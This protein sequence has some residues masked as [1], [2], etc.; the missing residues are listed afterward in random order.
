MIGFDE[1]FALVAQVARP[2][3]PETVGVSAARG[4]ILAAPITAMMDAPPADVSAMDGYAARQRDLE[5]GGTLHLVGTSYP[6]AGFAGGV[7][8][9]ECVRIFTGAPL[10]EGADRVVIQE[11]VERAD[12]Q[13]RVQGPLG[14]AGHVRQQGSDFRTGDRLLEAGRLLDHRSLVTAAGADV[15]EVQVWRRPRLSI[16]GTGDE[17]EEPG[18]A[19]ATPGRIPESVTLGVAALA[20]QWGADII[21][22]QR[23]KDDPDVMTAVAEEALAGSDLLVMT[24][25]ASVGEK[26]F[27]K[28][29]FVSLGL[30]IIFSKVAIK[31]GKPVWLG[32]VG[33]QLVMGLPGNPTSALVTARLL[34]A[35]LVAGLGGRQPTS[36]LFWREAYLADVLPACGGRETFFR[37]RW[38]GERVQLLSNQDSGAQRALAEADLLI[39]RRPGAAAAEP[40]DMV[41][42]IDF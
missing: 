2:L 24:G 20:E 8:A 40:G 5:D 19:R 14:S 6:G 33:D 22:R 35:P 3:G 11:I 21:R 26:D 17:L 10:P 25:G 42:V 28:A 1:A 34:L 29:V 12:D 30:E 38:T 36:P 4:R 13:V 27:A 18:R 31:P 32:R 39:R 9:G 23:L 16:L 7:S 41:E 37:G 15:G